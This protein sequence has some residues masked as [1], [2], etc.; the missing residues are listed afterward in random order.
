MCT[1]LDTNILLPSA[2]LHQKDGKNWAKYHKFLPSILNV[3]FRR[4][5]EQDEEGNGEILNSPHQGRTYEYVSGGEGIFIW[6]TPCK[7]IWPL[8]GNQCL[9]AKK[10]K[11]FICIFC[12]V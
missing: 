11:P 7:E 10:T 1:A 6:S 9:A 2:L 5:C 12:F 4:D 8:S 3:K